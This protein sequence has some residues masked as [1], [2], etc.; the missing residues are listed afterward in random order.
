MVLSFASAML[1][2]AG[3]GLSGRDQPSSESTVR[4]ALAKSPTVIASHQQLAQLATSETGDVA[5]IDGNARRSTRSHDDTTLELAGASESVTG[6]IAS[7]NQQAAMLRRVMHSSAGSSSQFLRSATSDAN[8]AL[9][10]AAV[11]NDTESSEHTFGNQPSTQI[12]IMES[13]DDPEVSAQESRVATLA[14][15]SSS[16]TTQA[17]DIA[18]EP[19]SLMVRRGLSHLQPRLFALSQ[20]VSPP[21][22]SSRIVVDL[23]DRQMMVW[24][25]EELIHTFPVAVGRVGW[26]T[27]AGEFEVLNKKENPTWQ[28]PLTDQV[29]PAGPNNPLGTHWIGFWTDGRNQIGFHG[30]TQTDLIGQAVSHG[31]IRMF[32]QHIEVLYDQVSVG[33]P[34]TIQQ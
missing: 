4:Q 24:Q 18:P 17:N 11:L 33:S 29:V 22:P 1:I 31:C 23:S 28:N 16:T 5:S 32:N 34:V 15:S 30:T 21:L 25:D 8:D 13:A 6:W 26:E 2:A 7:V 3:Q 10:R 19:D 12:P 20:Q 27:P 9:V 14:V